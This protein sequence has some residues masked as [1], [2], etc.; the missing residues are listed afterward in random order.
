MTLYKGPNSLF[1]ALAPHYRLNKAE[2]LQIYNL[3][4]TTQV[5][6]QLIIEEVCFTPYSTFSCPIPT[7]TRFDLAWIYSVGDIY[8]IYLA[9]VEVH[10][11]PPSST[12]S[13]LI[14]N[15]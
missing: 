2:F 3:K 1:R 5:E 10:P 14:S 12:P 15:I 7:P 11:P 4:P 13:A 6:L 9:S 8:P